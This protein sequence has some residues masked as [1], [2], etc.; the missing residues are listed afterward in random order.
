MKSPYYPAYT[1]PLL[2]YYRVL[3]AV[4]IV[5]YFIIS[6]PSTPLFVS[7]CPESLTCLP[8][9]TCYIVLKYL[10]SM[11]SYL[12]RH[13]LSL[14]RCPPTSLPPPLLPP[15]NRPH[16]F[17]SS[18]PFIV[19]CH[20][21]DPILFPSPCVP[22]E[23]HSPSC[24]ICLLGSYLLFSIISDCSALP[25]YTFLNPLCFSLLV[26]LFSLSTTI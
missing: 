24:A 6:R 9:P 7:V 18:T 19:C 5:L 21:L 12:T 1:P 11:Y 16:I 3:F 15:F 17:L 22:P 10:L 26:P 23:R 13:V 25:W 4:L 2:L 8:P 20:R 14:F